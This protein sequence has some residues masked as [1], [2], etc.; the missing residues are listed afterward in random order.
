MFFLPRVSHSDTAICRETRQQVAG[1]KGSPLPNTGVNGELRGPQQAGA[2]RREPDRPPLRAGEGW[3]GVLVCSGGSR[4]PNTVS[5]EALKGGGGGRGLVPAGPPWSAAGPRRG[6]IESW[7]ALWQD[8]RHHFAEVRPPPPK[9]PWSDVDRRGCRFAGG[10]GYSPRPN[11]PA[12]WSS[13]KYQRKRLG[14]I[15]GGRD[16]IPVLGKFPPPNPEYHPSR[17]V[18]LRSSL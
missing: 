5:G 4:L 16:G 11:S 1:W 17:N 7:E 14:S 3:G 8:A 2:G 12:G 18:E 15:L 10:S 6:C 9:G 13:W